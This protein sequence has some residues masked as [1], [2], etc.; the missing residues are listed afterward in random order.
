[1]SLDRADAII[2]GGPDVSGEEDLGVPHVSRLHVGLQHGPVRVLTF[3]YP[4]ALA[5]TLHCAQSLNTRTHLIY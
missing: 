4:L 2:E 1:M 3:A 5:R